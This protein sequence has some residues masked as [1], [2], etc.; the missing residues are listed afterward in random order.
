MLTLYCK[1]DARLQ[2]CSKE[3]CCVE[4]PDHECEVRCTKVVPDT[5]EEFEEDID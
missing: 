4:C 3:F 5:C 2:A 1:N